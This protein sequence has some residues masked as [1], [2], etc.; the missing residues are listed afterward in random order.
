MA[1]CL[2]I[3]V[4]F[5]SYAYSPRGYEIS[6]GC[7][8]ILRLIGNVRIGLDPVHEARAL[9]PGDLR[10]RVRMWGSGGLF[11][12]YGCVTRQGSENAPGTLPT[13]AKCVVVVTRE[14]TLV[15]SPDDVE[16]FVT[17]VQAF[18]L[19]DYTQNS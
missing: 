1:G 19:P 5:L 18:A 2:A 16:S 4:V 15:V 7:L 17:A 8:T 14:K 6:G 9:R 10:W 12:Y 3:L 13:G 11:G